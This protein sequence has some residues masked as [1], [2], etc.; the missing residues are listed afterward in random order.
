MVHS[1]KCKLNNPYG[2]NCQSADTL[3]CVM[4]SYHFRSGGS[5]RRH[6]CRCGYSTRCIRQ[7]VDHIITM[8]IPGIEAEE[9]DFSVVDL[10]EG[11]THRVSCTCVGSRLI[12]E[13]KW[14]NTAS[15]IS[16]IVMYT[17]INQNEF[18]EVDCLRLWFIQF[19]L[20]PPKKLSPIDFLV[21]LSHYPWRLWDDWEGT[22]YCSGL[23]DHI[24]SNE[25]I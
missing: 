15:E 21:F 14:L 10:V 17:W 5:Q 7:L 12:N 1:I 13:L 25:H 9:V 11:E 20:A 8:Q 23:E 4:C 2:P 6:R 16:L 19:L 3:L 22:A 18:A 24:C